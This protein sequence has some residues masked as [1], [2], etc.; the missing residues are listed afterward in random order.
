MWKRIIKW[1]KQEQA[2]NRLLDEMNKIAKAEIVVKKKRIK[3]L[4]EE[5]NQLKDICPHGV[6]HQDWCDD[7]PNDIAGEE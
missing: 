4:K 7:C 1:W 2:R 3:E 6:S 5:I